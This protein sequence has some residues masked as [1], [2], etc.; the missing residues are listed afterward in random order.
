MDDLETIGE[1]MLFN[2]YNMV[3]YPEYS[4]SVGRS[5]LFRA[6]ERALAGCEY[7]GKEWIE[8][9]PTAFDGRS[10]VIQDV[11]VELVELAS[12]LRAFLKLH[13]LVELYF[14]LE[15][16]EYVLA[17]VGSNTDLQRRRLQWRQSL[18]TVI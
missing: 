6:A 14:P 4:I 13:D 10:E 17:F 2:F 11:L 8:H 16:I 3:E 7:S 12:E 18:G 1:R 5:T 9:Y 15:P